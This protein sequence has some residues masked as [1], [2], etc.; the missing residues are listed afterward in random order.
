MI[1]KE[2]FCKAMR[3]R[4]KQIERDSHLLLYFDTLYS[5]KGSSK[6]LK[7][8]EFGMDAF[9]LVIGE[10]FQVEP[11]VI[12]AAAGLEEKEFGPIQ[13]MGADGKKHS[14]ST[15]EAFYDY[16]VKRMEAAV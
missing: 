16:L 5:Q 15:Y 10:L 7:L 3:L 8:P 4:D 1:S 6:A 11:A 9:C 13:L 12:K 14:F 2:T